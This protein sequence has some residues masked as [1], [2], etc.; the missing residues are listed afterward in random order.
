MSFFCACRSPMGCAGYLL[1][2]GFPIR[3]PGRRA[4][5]N[6]DPEK[7]TYHPSGEKYFSKKSQ[8]IKMKMCALKFAIQSGGPPQPMFASALSPVN[9]EKIWRSR[10]DSLELSSHFDRASIEDTVTVAVSQ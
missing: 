6:F 10:I 1:N 4:H 8:K 7:R 5:P 3:N 2:F 9:D